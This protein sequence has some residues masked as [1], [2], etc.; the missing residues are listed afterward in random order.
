[1]INVDDKEFKELCKIIRRYV[2]FK[3]VLYFIDKKIGEEFYQKQE[4]Y[5]KLNLQNHDHNDGHDH[6]ESGNCCGESVLNN[7][8]KLTK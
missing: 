3:K 1:M 5:Y 4:A 8:S 6:H 7:T 2:N